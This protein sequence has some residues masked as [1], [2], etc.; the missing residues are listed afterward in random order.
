MQEAQGLL[1]I[2]KT[3]QLTG[4]SE[5]TLR[6]WERRYDLLAPRRT[7]AGYRL[8]DQPTLARIRAMQDLVRAGWTPKA[9]AAELSVHPPESRETQEQRFDE[10]VQAAAELDAATIEKL[11]D[12]NLG[13]GSLEAAIDGWL[14]PAMTRLGRAW[15]EQQVSVAGEH[16]VAN[17]VMRRLAQAFD[18]ARRGTTG[19]PVLV[20]A[21]PGVEHQI[22]LLAFAVACRR[23]HV[24]TVYL[25]AKVPLPAWADAVARTHAFAVVT[26]VPQ[27]RDAE[28]VLGMLEQ[29]R[30]RAEA[31]VW[32]GGRFQHLIPEPARQLGHQIGPA[33]ATLAAQRRG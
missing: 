3:A 20:G 12:E 19:R 30:D 24:P 29:L 21:P 13:H 22:G 26:S 23:A 15:T 31:T 32:V 1:T 9:A 6:A 27:R 18:A 16:L 4:I 2:G 7:P 11:V 14:M 33:A 17:T 28:R 5:H 10:L 25:G 8:Y